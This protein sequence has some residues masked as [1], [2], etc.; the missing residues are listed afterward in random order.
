MHFVNLC[1]RKGLR[2][3]FLAGVVGASAALQCGFMGTA[4]AAPI[5]VSS[6]EEAM[7]L[8]GSPTTVWDPKGATEISANGL[9][10]AHPGNSEYALMYFNTASAVANLNSQYGVNSWTIT[11]VSVQF[12]S[13][14][15]TKNVFPNNAVF[16]E[17][18][19]GSFNLSWL[20]NNGWVSSSSGGVTWNNLPNYLPGTGTNQE[21]G[22]GTFSFAADGTNPI[23][24]ALSPTSDFLSSIDAGGGVTLYGTPADTGVGYLINAPTQGSPAVLQITAQATPV[25]EPAC[26]GFIGLAGV[27]LVRRNRSD[28]LSQ[29][30][31]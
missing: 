8:S 25:P 19:P 26:L 17:I 18:E 5:S 31:F 27:V 1:L 22:E 2:F 12:A 20:S 21:E 24:W 6:T 28:L 10:S 3:R 13:N 14:F 7:V 9:N 11:S 30:L 29:R 4:Q 16:N 15:A 23:T